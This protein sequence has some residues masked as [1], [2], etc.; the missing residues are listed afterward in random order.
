MLEYL[1]FLFVVIKHEWKYIGEQ[2]SFMMVFKMAF[3]VCCMKM[4][5]E[6]KGNK[7]KM[8]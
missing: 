2:N 7:Y 1:I 8:R 4:R 5:D 6:E 3:F